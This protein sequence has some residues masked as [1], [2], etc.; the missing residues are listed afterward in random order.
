MA[1]GRH[2]GKLVIAQEPQPFVIRGDATYLITG[3]LGGLGLAVA[4]WLT[5]EGA[6]HLVMVGRSAPQE[7]ANIVLQKLAEAGVEIKVIQADVS[8]RAA[9][10]DLFAQIETSMPP[11]KGVIHA[12]GA[13]SDGVITQQTWERFAT[14]YA[15]KVQGSWHLHELTKGMALD[16]FVLFSSA[17]S[18]LGSAGQANHV[19][20]S[21]FQDMLAHYRRSQGLPALSIGWGPWTQIGAAAEREV[22]DRLLNR[23]IETIPPAQ[24]IESLAKVMHA[25]KLTHVGIVPINWTSFM[26][27]SAAPFFTEMRQQV[28]TQT[29]RTAAPTGQTKDENELWKR[30]ESAPESKRKNI[31]LEHVR[32]QALKV[33]NLPGDYPLEQRQPLQELGLD[34]LMAVELR[35]RLGKGLPLTRS[36]PA[37]LVFDYPTPDALSRYLLDTLFVKDKGEEPAPQEKKAEVAIDAELSDE[38]AEALLLAELNELQQKKTG[39]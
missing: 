39:K 33:L 30:L 15:S 31:L 1:Q 13:L 9:M 27:Q 18:L 28:K 20:A 16:F 17:V 32:E 35:N 14:V 3:G 4:E 23:G 7:Q 10:D 29:V 25:P 6:R 34:S 38:E 11:L 5:Q 26:A 12:A 36:L 37:T 22:F 2:T 8:K 21:T 19:A 24:G